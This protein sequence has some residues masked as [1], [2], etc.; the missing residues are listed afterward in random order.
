MKYTGELT[1][2]GEEQFKRLQD[3]TGMS[4]KAILNDALALLWWAVAQRKAGRQVGSFPPEGQEGETRELRMDI[5]D[6]I[7]PQN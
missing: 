2:E 5:L 7:Q 4:L 3:E 1:K 6:K